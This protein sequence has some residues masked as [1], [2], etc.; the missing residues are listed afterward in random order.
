MS[1]KLPRLVLHFDVNGTV[2]ITDPAAGL[3]FEDAIEKAL[4]QA[5]WINSSTYPPTL[6]VSKPAVTKTQLADALKWPHG[7]PIVPELC[8]DG[9]HHFMF[10]SFYKAITELACAKRASRPPRLVTTGGFFLSLGCRDF[11]AKLFRMSEC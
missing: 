10:P 4:D 7:Y 1:S 2:I 11:S 6:K 9:N 3:S 5:D 8:M